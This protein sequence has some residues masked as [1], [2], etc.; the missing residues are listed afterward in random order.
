MKPALFSRWNTRRDL[1]AVRRP[2]ACGCRAG[3]RTHGGAPRSA[4]RPQSGG[5][6][7]QVWRTGRRWGIVAGAGRTV[8]APL[9]GGGGQERGRRGGTPAAALITGFAAA[10]L[11]AEPTTWP[12]LPICGTRPNA[13]P[14]P[15]VPSCA[16]TRAAGWQTRR[17]SP[18]PGPRPEC[19]SS[20]WIWKK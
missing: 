15:M 2:A 1:P 17:A 19:R 3:G 16:A 8:C 18:C 10:A 11:A 9:I 5:L 20:R 7:A 6:L 4:G 12:L 13:R 14:S